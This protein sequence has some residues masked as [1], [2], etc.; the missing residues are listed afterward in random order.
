MRTETAEDAS[1]TRRAGHA[2]LVCGGSHLRYSLTLVPVV[3]EHGCP[4]KSGAR[5]HA[6]SADRTDTGKEFLR[7]VT[8]AG[9]RRCV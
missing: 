4:A 6:A 5:P 1:A 9:R 7:N 3:L 8:H 2:S